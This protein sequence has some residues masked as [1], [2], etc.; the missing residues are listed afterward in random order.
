MN[1]SNN[2]ASA[3]PAGALAA[4]SQALAA[5]VERIGASTLAVRGRRHAVASGV[6]WREG[7]VVTAAHVFRRTPAAATLV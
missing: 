7:I 3:A 4:H 1:S 5:I 2:D 6:V